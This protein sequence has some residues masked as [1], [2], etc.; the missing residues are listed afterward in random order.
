VEGD[1]AFCVSFQKR[2]G[3]SRQQGQQVGAVHRTGPPDHRPR[4][5]R[6]QAHVALL[7]LLLDLRLTRVG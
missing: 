1:S 4:R 7:L 3:M 5:V 2:F 6:V